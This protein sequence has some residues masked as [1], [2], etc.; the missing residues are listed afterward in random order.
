MMSVVLVLLYLGYAFM[1]H[2]PV[3]L[4]LFAPGILILFSLWFCKKTL[5]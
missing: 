4:N 3:W 2:S 1:Y 5:G